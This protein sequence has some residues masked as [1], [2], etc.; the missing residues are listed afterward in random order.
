MHWSRDGEMWK[1]DSLA[2]KKR[3]T[4]DRNEERERDKRESA[5]LEQRW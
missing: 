2:M 4:L 1:N 3:E 5:Y